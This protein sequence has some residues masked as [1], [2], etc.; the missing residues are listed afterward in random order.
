MV[1]QL[2]EDGFLLDECG[3]FIV[4]QTNNKIQLSEQQI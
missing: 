2:D 1:Y 4:D 3:R